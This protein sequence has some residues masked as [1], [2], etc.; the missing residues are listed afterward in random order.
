M[1]Y[2]FQ[3][4]VTFDNEQVTDGQAREIVDGI[5]ARGMEDLRSQ[6][7]DDDLCQE[8]FD[9]NDPFKLFEQIEDIKLV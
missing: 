6:L 3:V 7:D 5:I 9:D 4:E 1:K 2:T 8:D